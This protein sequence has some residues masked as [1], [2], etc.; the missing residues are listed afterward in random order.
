M[1]SYLDRLNLRPFE[2]RLV[3]GV[4]AVLFLVLNA[5]FVVPHFSDLNQA[6]DRRVQ[7]LE[8][9]KTWQI[10]M[11]QKVK[12]DAGINKF[13]QEGLEVPPED[14]QNQFARAIQDQQVRSGVGIQQFGRVT[15][16]SNQFFLELTQPISVQSG[17]EQLVDFLY[18]LGSG[19]S[20]I[21]VRDLTLRPDA[22]RQQLSGTVKLVASY[23]KNPPKKATPATSPAAAKT[24]ITTSTAKRP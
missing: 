17:E 23:Q 7:A 24:K 11:D 19:N 22:P 5:W 4:G 18:R 8:K 9:L 6:R 2:K 1:T 10:E 20:L 13:R 3:V 21:R 14:Q 15:T 12:Y 16:Q